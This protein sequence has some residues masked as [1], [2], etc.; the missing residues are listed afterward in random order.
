[1][2]HVTFPQLYPLGPLVW[3]IHLIPDTGSAQTPRG[4]RVRLRNL[5]YE[6]GTRLDAAPLDDVTQN[7]LLEFQLDRDVPP[8]GK[9]EDATTKKLTQV[10]GS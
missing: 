4:A 9:L 10:Y 8:T 3:L 7:A 2:A 5:G 1:M 6:P